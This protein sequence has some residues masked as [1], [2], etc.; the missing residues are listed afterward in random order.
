MRPLI[1]D[2]DG[3][4]NKER[5]NYILSPEEWEPIPGSLEAIARAKS[6]GFYIIVISN[7]SAIGRGW[8]SVDTLNLINQKMQR[9]L[10]KLGGKIDIFLFCPHLPTDNCDCRKPSATLLNNLKSRMEI[11]FTGCLLVGD[12]ISDL[13]VAQKIGARPILV[14]S[15][16]SIC[17]PPPRIAI[18]KD[19]STALKKTLFKELE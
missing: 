9:K 10:A 18:F 19:L 3:V 8:M 2:R 1:L 17:H 6:L 13:E 16:K 14:E 5:D 11:D 4:I 15:G 7:Q 12:R